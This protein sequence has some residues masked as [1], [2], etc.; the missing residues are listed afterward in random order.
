[1]GARSGTGSRRA[2][3]ID[4]LAGR[5]PLGRGALGGL[6]LDPGR[7]LGARPAR[8]ARPRLG[9]PARARRRSRSRPRRPRRRPADRRPR[10]RPA[11]HRRARCASPTGI[12][13]SS[14]RP[15]P[16]SASSATTPRA[17]ARRSA[18][19]TCCASRCAS[20]TAQAAV[21][22]AHALGERRHHLRGQRAPA[23]PRGA[24]PTRPPVTRVRTSSPRSTATS[25][26]TPT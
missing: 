15:R 2:R 24:R 12:S 25:T 22:V 8:G 23:E 5:G 1:M 21:L 26:T 19:T 3:A 9:R 20:D 16:R 7:A 13:R 11:V 14:T 18:P 17:C 6:P 4:D 10:R